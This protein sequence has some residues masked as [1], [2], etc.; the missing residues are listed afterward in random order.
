MKKNPCECEKNPDECEKNPDECEKNPD[1]SEKIRASGNLREKF[2]RRGADGGENANVNFFR[3]ARLVAKRYLFVFHKLFHKLFHTHMEKNHTRVHTHLEKI[4]THLEKIHTRLEKIHMGEIH[5]GE[6]HMEEIHMEEI[7]MGRDSHMV[8]GR[9]GLPFKEGRVDGISLMAS[10][11]VG[12]GPR[13]SVC[14]CCRSSALRPDAGLLAL[15]MM[16]R[17]FV[18]AEWSSVGF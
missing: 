5:L 17:V 14:S 10:C 4:H 9:S 2:F 18:L 13:I 7:H 11:E 1:G 12:F 8:G 3:G 6:I 15:A 16:F